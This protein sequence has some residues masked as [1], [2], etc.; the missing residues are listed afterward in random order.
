[1][2]ENRYVLENPPFELAPNA[3]ELVRDPAVMA[4]V[5]QA[6]ER[7]LSWPEFQHKSWVPGNKRAVWSLVQVARRIGRAPTPIQDERGTLY[8]FNPS[9]HAEFLHQ[10]DLELGGMFLGIEYFN[11]ADKRHIL[12]RNLIEESI[13]SSQLE[14]ANTSRAAAKKMLAEGRA[15]RDK[16]EHMI[17]NNHETMR[18]IEEEL[19]D[20][21]L[22][23]DLLFDLHRRITKNTIPEPHQGTLRN[24]LDE[25]GEP[26]VI[27]PWD[28]SVIAYVTPP[29]EFVEKNLPI[30]IS[31]AND[32]VRTPTFVHPLIKAIMLHFWMG[33][34]HPF[35]DGNGRLARILFYW[36]MLRKKYWAFA[37]LSISERILKSP[38]Q[39]A[40]SFIY[41]EQDNFD[42][43]YFI[44][45]NIAKIKLAR[46]GLEEYVRNKIT[47]NKRTSEAIKKG[48]GLNA[49]QTALLQ[50]LV[51]DEQRHTS[52]KEHMNFHQGIGKVTAAT[53]LRKLVEKGFLK[54]A[55]S[56]RNIYYY[57][58]D[59]LREL[60]R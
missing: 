25:K 9:A 11:E 39:Y 3:E 5:A 45:Y 22:S 38:R 58:T 18:W 37:Y 48:F 17:M 16:S 34:L 51:K 14:G 12:R 20:Q 1:M 46:R 27:K 23:M 44:H 28:E 52:L 60:L 33:L 13:A 36:Y 15:P 2:V 21:K 10:V 26:L 41:A 43:N 49:R 40:M 30:L 4:A 31:F 42:L 59:Q 35:E 56:G 24:T 50:S 29:K 54:K 57:P 53:D 6:Q 55:R 47:E 7:Y 8:T 19:K 32:E